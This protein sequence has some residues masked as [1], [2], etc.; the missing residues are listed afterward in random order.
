MATSNLE[1][2]LDFKPYKPKKGEDYMSL[3]QINHFK[4]YTL[5]VEKTAYV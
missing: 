3:E 5:F 2:Y 4:K 1:K